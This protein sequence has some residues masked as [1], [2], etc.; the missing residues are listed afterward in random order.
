[1]TAGTAATEPAAVPAAE[2]A[3][4]LAHEPA[5]IQQAISPDHWG[6]GREGAL[7]VA[8]H[9]QTASCPQY[10]TPVSLR[11]DE[12]DETGYN[13]DT[14]GNSLVVGQRTLDPRG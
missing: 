7:A 6:Q 5:G 9:A 4:G 11:V 13:T 3:K 12:S 8:I 10:T 2:K 1:M 14:L